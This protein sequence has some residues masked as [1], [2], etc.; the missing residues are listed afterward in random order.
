LFGHGSLACED[1]ASIVG[2]Q[3]GIGLAD[4][5]FEKCLMGRAALFENGFDMASFE[6][7]GCRQKDALQ[8][9]GGNGIGLDAGVGDE[10]MRFMTFLPFLD[11]P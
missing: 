6:R 3:S 8:F 5:R 10:R 9:V 7:S 11:I 2:I 1:E 4:V